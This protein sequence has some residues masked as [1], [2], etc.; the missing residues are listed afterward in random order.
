[1]RLSWNNIRWNTRN[2]LYPSEL[3][4]TQQKSK[5]NTITG[6]YGEGEGDLDKRKYSGVI[7]VLISI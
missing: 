4:K 2:L 1:M 6:N 5:I 3:R 7:F